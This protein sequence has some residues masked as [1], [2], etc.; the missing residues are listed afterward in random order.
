MTRTLSVPFA[1][2]LS[3]IEASRDAL[4]VPNDAR[5]IVTVLP[6]R[7]LAGN[8]CFQIIPDMV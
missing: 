3:P 1:P 2:A 7:P 8:V 5:K 4:V 6:F